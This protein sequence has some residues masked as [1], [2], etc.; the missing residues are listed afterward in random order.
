LND[1]A[2]RFELPQIGEMKRELVGRLDYSGYI[3][4]GYGIDS[5][6]L[7][8][9]IAIDRVRRGQ[10]LPAS[11]DLLDEEIAQ[12]ADLLK[13]LAERHF[14]IDLGIAERAY[15]A[16]QLLS[17]VIS[18]SNLKEHAHMAAERDRAFVESV[19]A[20]VRQEYSG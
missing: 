13:G 17:L 19:I 9:A 7:H 16:K 14:D 18:T 6:M 15:L 10:T 5:V 8:F 12:V 11:D 4:N 3:I 20:Q 2:L 1:I